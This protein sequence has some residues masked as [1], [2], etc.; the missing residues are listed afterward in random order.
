[1]RKNLMFAGAF[2]VTLMLTACGSG[3][4][5]KTSEKYSAA[6]VEQADK[7]MKYY[8]ASLALLDIWNRMGM[9]RY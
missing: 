6:E 3:V 8:N 2:A 4:Q 7:V 9:R 5:R 1:M